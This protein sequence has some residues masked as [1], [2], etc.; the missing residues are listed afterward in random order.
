MGQLVK[1]INAI[2]EESKEWD[3]DGQIEWDITAYV[4]SLTEGFE[5]QGQ[6]RYFLDIDEGK[7]HRDYI[8]K[9]FPNAKPARLIKVVV[10]L[11][12]K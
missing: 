3:P 8:N 12:R 11:N 7:K 5:Y 10:K 6:K 1:E 2:R 9:S 4:L